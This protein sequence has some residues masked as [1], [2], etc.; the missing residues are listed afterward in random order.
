MSDDRQ[1]LLPATSVKQL[2][3]P[4]TKVIVDLPPASFWGAP[5]YDETVTRDNVFLEKVNDYFR[6]SVLAKLT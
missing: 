2:G 3:W 5:S 6:E 1:V 4:E